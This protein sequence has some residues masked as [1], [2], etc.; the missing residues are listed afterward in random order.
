M[1]IDDI[2]EE[3]VPLD[4]RAMSSAQRRQ[5][6]LT[7]PAGSLGRLEELSVKLAGIYREATPKVGRKVIVVAAADH[8]VTEEGVSAYPSEVTGQMV[9][10]FLKGGAAINV[11]ARHVEAEVVVV[12]AGVKAK[13]PPSENLRSLRIGPGTKNMA[14]GPAMTRA[15]ALRCLE[16]G[17]CLAEELVGDGASLLATGDMGIGNTTSASA[18]TSAITGA[19]SEAVTGRGTG[20]SEEVWRRKAEVLSRALRVN[21]PDPEDAIDVLSKVGG[22]E[23]GMLAG[24]IL[25]GAKCGRPVVL[26]GFISGA[27][28]LIAC[29]IAPRA[30]E[31]LIASHRSVEPGHRRQL[32]HL[33]LKPL[34]DMRM[35]LGEGTGAALAM[36]IIEGAAKCLSE[37][38][39][40]S[41]AGVSERSEQRQD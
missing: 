30:R 22:F 26:D 29:G 14:K 25:G 8:G 4:R 27:S 24:V 1:W 2:N 37:M 5:A 33:R 21:G 34:L 12:D 23:I 15:Q 10:N 41:S 19:L 31:Y 40:F 18:V 11:L 36:P 38:S 9:L 39:T 6:I 7:K 32:A 13:L 20:I 16:E 3:I 17:M 35:R 28:A